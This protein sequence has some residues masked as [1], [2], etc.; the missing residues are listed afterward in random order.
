MGTGELV[1]EKGQWAHAG[2]CGIGT[3]CVLLLAPPDLAGEK[4]LQESSRSCVF[5]QGLDLMVAQ[6]CICERGLVI[7]PV[8]SVHVCSSVPAG[9]RLPEGQKHFFFLELGLPAVGTESPQRCEGGPGLSPGGNVSV[10][11]PVVEEY[12]LAGV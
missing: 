3:G 6:D 7:V 5:Q 10:P 12:L 2:T 11:M 9:V 8:Q 4:W 1:E